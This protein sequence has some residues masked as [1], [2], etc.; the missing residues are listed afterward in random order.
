MLKTLI[1]PSEIGKSWTLNAKYVPSATDVSNTK[2]FFLKY[3]CIPRQL[4]YLNTWTNSYWEFNSSNITI[5]DD[6][7]DADID[8]LGERTRHLW[9]ML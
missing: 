1:F 9:N 8:F 2:I 7:A 5:V 6:C 4:R 3:E